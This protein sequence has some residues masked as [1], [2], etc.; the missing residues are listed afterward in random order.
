MRKGCSLLGQVAQLLQDFG[1]LCIPLAISLRSLWW[2][3]EDMLLLLEADGALC[4]CLLWCCTICGGCAGVTS[5]CERFVWSGGAD[6]VRAAG[7]RGL[8]GMRNPL[9]C[10]GT[11]RNNIVGQALQQLRGQVIILTSG[12]LSIGFWTFLHT[13]ERLHLNVHARYCERGSLL[14]NLVHSLGVLHQNQTEITRS[15]LLVVIRSLSKWLHLGMSHKNLA[16]LPISRKELL[17]HVLGAETQPSNATSDENAPRVLIAQ[18]LQVRPHCFVSGCALDT[19]CGCTWSLCRGLVL[20]LW[21]HLCCLL[22][23]SLLAL[24]RCWHSVRYC[25]QCPLLRGLRLIQCPGSGQEGGWRQ[26]CQKLFLSSRLGH[27]IRGR[28]QPWWWSE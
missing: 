26:I 20:P 28:C 21:L 18:G 17:Q 6:L 4:S 12:L 11:I 10:R 24:C 1:N 22:W 13:K 15:L 8:A 27:A 2:G 9:S 14:K 25:T 16:N 3:T 7:T 19:S 23:L 5:T